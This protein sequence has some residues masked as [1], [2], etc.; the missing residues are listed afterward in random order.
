MNLNNDV[1]QKVSEVSM[2]LILFIERSKAV[3]NNIVFRDSYICGKIIMK[4]K[5]LLTHNSE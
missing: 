3:T 2:H 4:N 5:E 1:E